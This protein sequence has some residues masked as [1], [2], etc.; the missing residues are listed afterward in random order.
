MRG[1]SGQQSL[2]V[3]SLWVTYSERIIATSALLLWGNGANTGQVSSV[4]SATLSPEAV[5]LRPTLHF[6]HAWP[7]G[8]NKSCQVSSL[9]SPTPRDN[10]DFRLLLWGNGAK[11]GPVSVPSA[12]LS[13]E[14]VAL[15]RHIALLA[16]VAH[17]AKQVCQVSSLWVTYSREIM[18]DFR[19][20]LWGNGAKYGPVSVPSAT[21]FT[22]SGGTETPHCTLACVAHRA[23]QVCQVS[24]LWVTYSER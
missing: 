24:S 9:W 22:G 14:A 23:K 10:R 17:R 11:Y 4:P 7:I 21:L 16:C 18:R 20:L 3:S 1:P 12:T 19:L 15:R 5:A 2:Q 13:P 6:W 8:P